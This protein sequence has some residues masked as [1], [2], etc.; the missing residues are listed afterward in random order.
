VT[1]RV[2]CHTD[3]PQWRDL[4]QGRVGSSDAAALLGVSPWCSR[5]ELYARL[6]GVVER[7]DL[8]DVEHVEIGLALEEPLGRLLA[9]RLGKPLEPWGLL[10]QSVAYPWAVCTPDWRTPAGEPVE[11]KTVGT[12]A[13][14]RWTAGEVPPHY[15]AQV[16]HQ[17][18]VTGAERAIVGVLTA[19]PAFRLLWARVP[20]NLDMVARIVEAGED[21]Q[22]RLR[23]QDPPPPDD[24]ESASHALTALYPTTEGEEYVALPPEAEAWDADLQQVRVRIRADEARKRELDG[25]LKHAIADAAGGVLPSGASYRASRYV[26]P[27][28]VIEREEYRVFRLTRREAR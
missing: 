15:M 5:L 13:L 27:A 25:L 20:G 21:M 12:A 28:A 11:L 23:E 18:L 4:H 17:M 16:Q 6:L 24:S 1:Y 7:P 14:R 8:G 22:R 26:V 19:S 2:L 3:D 9:E 10:L